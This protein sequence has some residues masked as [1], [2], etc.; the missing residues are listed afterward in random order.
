MADHTN[1]AVLG[2]NGQI[3]SVLLRHLARI[4][5]VHP[6][7]ICRNALGAGLIS[8]I[9]CDVR[10]GS[11]TS[12]EFD[13]KLIG[14]CDSMINCIWPQGSMKAVKKQN[15]ILLSNIHGNAN[16]KRFISLS[17]VAVYGP[18]IDA[19]WSTFEAPKPNISYGQLKLEM[20]KKIAK[21]FAGST[22]RYHLIRLG[23]VYGKEQW[24]SRA[25]LGSITDHKF[26]LPF[27]GGMSS[28]T[29]HV[30]ELAHG[31]VYLLLNPQSSGVLNLASYP[32]KTWRQ[33]FDLHSEVCGLPKVISMDFDRSSQYRKSFISISRTSL[34]RKSIH[35]FS[36]WLRSISPS[37]LLDNPDVKAVGSMVLDRLPGTIERRLKALSAIRTVRGQINALKVAPSVDLMYCCDAMPGKYLEIPPLDE[38][39]LNNQKKDLHEWYKKAIVGPIG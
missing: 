24:C 33:V 14:D 35:A 30:D 12:V 23:H 28:N 34:L 17:S 10:L 21:C 37:A 36:E 18:C 4:P 22:C 11:I 20:E 32:Q 2:A 5:G 27:E 31:L 3:G 38:A 1:V 26:R 9:K 19:S 29:V 6:I 39:I 15:E 13:P 16:L 8:D 25:I 7:A